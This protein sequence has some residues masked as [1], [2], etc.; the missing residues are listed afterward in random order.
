MQIQRKNVSRKKLVII[1]LAALLL[2]GGTAA[3]LYATNMWPFTKN[4]DTE[5]NKIDLSKP[6]EEA[7][8]TGESIK[9]QNTD[10]QDKVDNSSDRAVAPETSDG[11]KAASGLRI[12]SASQNDDQVVIRILIPVLTGSGTCELTMDGP[13]GAIFNSSASVQALSSSSTCEGFN[14]PTAQLANGTWKITVELNNEKLSG[15]DTSEV[16]VK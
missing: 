15:S 14:V 7:K 12:T 9:K 2:V 1:A 11:S 13:N 10:S 8:E 3:A 4:A 6:S 5:V 16:T